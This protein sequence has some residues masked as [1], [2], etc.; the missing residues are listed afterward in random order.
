MTPPSRC[1]IPVGGKTKN[2]TVVVLR[3]RSADLE[4]PGHPAAAYIYSPDRKGKHPA[5]H[6]AGFR[7]K[8]QV[9]GYTG[10]PALAKRGT[11]ELVFCWAHCRRHFYDFHAATKSPLAAEAL[12]QIARLYAIEAEI[13]G[14]PPEHRRAVRQQ[15]SRPIV[16]TLQTWLKATLVRVSNSSPLADAIRYTLRH[17]S[18]L[19]TVP[20]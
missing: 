3:G 6:L 17:W 8:L 16:E 20:R 18:G 5:E 10:F 19:G 14:Q 4:R 12:A 13:R 15:R 9:D 1:S 2:R 11:I 7:G